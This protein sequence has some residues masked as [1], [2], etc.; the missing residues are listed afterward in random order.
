MPPGDTFRPETYFSARFGDRRKLTIF[1]CAKA[2]KDIISM[3]VE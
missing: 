2:K 3:P 1:V